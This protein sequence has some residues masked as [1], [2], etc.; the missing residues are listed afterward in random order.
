MYIAAKKK[1]TQKYF[2]YF[3]RKETYQEIKNLC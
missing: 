2:N 1:A 3:K